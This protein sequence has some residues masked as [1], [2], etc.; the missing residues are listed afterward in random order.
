MPSLMRSLQAAPPSPRPTPEYPPTSVTPSPTL[1]LPDY[2]IPPMYLMLSGFKCAYSPYGEHNNQIYELFGKTV[3]DRPFYRGMQ[4]TTTYL[5]YNTHC[6][7]GR[8][9]TQVSAWRNP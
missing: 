1:T 6:S 4:T 7:G 5:F 8:D 9:G 3:D 2:M